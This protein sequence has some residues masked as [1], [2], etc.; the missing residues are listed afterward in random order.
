MSS[1]NRVFNKLAGQMQDVTGLGSGYQGESGKITSKADT[2]LDNLA[3]KIITTARS[4]VSGRI[5]ALD[6]EMLQGIVN[7]FQ[8]G[9]FKTDTQARDSLVA[10]RNNLALMYSE[11]QSRLTF[12]TEQKQVTEIR[13]LRSSVENLIAETTGAIAIYD[14]FIMGDPIAD[15]IGDRASSVTSSLTRSSAGS[16]P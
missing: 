1:V 10:V 14:K 8:P 15:T 2:Q 5:F 12:T 16:N 9:G 4:G 6:V 13:R 11:A 7:G 3:R